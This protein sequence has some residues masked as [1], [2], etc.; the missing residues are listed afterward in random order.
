MSAGPPRTSGWAATS[1]LAPEEEKHKLYST[2][3]PRD[4]LFFIR[5][6]TPEPTPVWLG[7]STI[8]LKATAAMLVQPVLRDCRIARVQENNFTGCAVGTEA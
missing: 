6:I 5:E 1:C 3:Q 4:E 7:V 2:K 8:A